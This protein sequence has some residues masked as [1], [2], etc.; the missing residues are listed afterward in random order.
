MGKYM[1]T[2]A[3]DLR[4]ETPAHQHQRDFKPAPQGGNFGLVEADLFMVTLQA[5]PHA[6]AEIAEI[7]RID[8]TASGGIELAPLTEQTVLASTK[9]KPRVPSGNVEKLFVETA[10]PTGP[11]DQVHF[12]DPVT[13]VAGAVC[14]PHWMC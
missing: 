2:I 4:P 9:G 10:V 8:R 1:S 11:I 3:A 14:S 7:A 5:E 13:Y 6:A 12:E